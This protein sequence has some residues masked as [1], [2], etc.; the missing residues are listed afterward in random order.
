MYKVPRFTF[1]ILVVWALIGVVRTVAS[2]LS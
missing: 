2:F 1:W